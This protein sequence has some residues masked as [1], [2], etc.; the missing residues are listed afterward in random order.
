MC[1]WAMDIIII[2]IIIRIKHKKREREINFW[3]TTNNIPFF[4]LLHL[5]LQL[6]SHP[7]LSTALSMFWDFLFPHF[8]LFTLSG[9]RA[10]ANWEHEAWRSTRESQAER[11][12]PALSS[13]FGAF[14]EAFVAAD[15]QPETTQ[16]GIKQASVR[17]FRKLNKNWG[18]ITQSD[19]TNQWVRNYTKPP[20]NFVFIQ[21]T[22]M[23]LLCCK[24][25]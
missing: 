7:N 17:N 4:L 3:L 8:C 11:E 20:T 16:D 21:R 9:G 25:V 2:I 18:Y 6:M 10:K 15:Y 13:V 19:R 22:P 1:I 5:L 14:V 12:L 23:S 24:N